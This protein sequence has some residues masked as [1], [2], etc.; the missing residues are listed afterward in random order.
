V[1]LPFI[2]YFSPSAKILPLTIMTASLEECRELGAGIARAVRESGRKVVIVASSD[3]SHYL[4][5]N[6]ARSLDRLALD[7]LLGL[8]PEGLFAVVKKE[9]ISMCG[10]LAATVMLF[11]S[12][13]LGAGKTRLV[14]YA[15]SGDVSGDYEQVVGYA[16]VIVS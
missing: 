3:M 15:T 1:Q 8:D 4:P 16:G 12:L 2:G 14:K 13:A 10:Y 5:D 7:E 9:G 6:I 11:A